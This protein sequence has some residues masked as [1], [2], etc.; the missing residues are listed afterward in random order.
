MPSVFDKSLAEW[1]QFL[2]WLTLA[3]AALAFL[4]FQ[5]AA[6]EAQPDPDRVELTFEGNSAKSET[7][8]RQAAAV[9]LADFEHNGQRRADMD[10]A[11][12]QMASAYR[13][14][15]Y[16]FAKVGYVISQTGGLCTVAFKIEEGPRVLVDKITITGNQAVDRAAIESLLRGDHLAIFGK[17]AHPFVKSDIESAIDS[18][19]D[20]YLNLGFLDVVVPVPQYTFHHDRTRVDI[21]SQIKEGILYRVRRVTFSGDVPADANSALDGLNR[22]MVDQPYTRRLDL[23]VKARAGE[24]LGNLGYPEPAIDVH[25]RLPEGPGPVDLEVDIAKGP[26]V[27]IQDIRIQGVGQ[28]REEFI[29]NRMK[30]K[31][32]DRFNLA[33]ERESSSELFKSGVFSKCDIELEKTEDPSQRVLVVKV[34]EAQ[35]QEV[36][37]EPG[38]GSY[39]QLMMKVGYRHKNVF[40]SALSWNTEVSGSRKAQG[41]SSAL[42]DPWFLDTDL[43]SDL[44]GFADRREEPAFTRRDYGGSFFLTKYLNPSLSLTG[45]YT[46][47]N[48][49][50]SG[51]GT[52]EQEEDFPQNY[53][54]SSVKLQ[55]TYDTRN[56]LFFP[57]TGQRIFSAVEQADSWLGGD[58]NFTRLTLGSRIFF[59]IAAATVLGLRY[60]TGLIIPGRENLTVPPSERFFNGGENTVRSF[61]EFKLGP[62]NSSGKPTGGLGYNVFSVEL[63]QRLIGNFT[64]SIFGD[65]GNVSP[66]RTRAEEGESAYRNHE[67]VTSDTLSDFFRGLRPA[68]GFGLQ[69]QLPIGPARVDVGFNPDRD[70]SRDEDLYVVHLSVGMAF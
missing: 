65:L 6:V 2:R 20:L 38:W 55:I 44:T 53:D 8:L 32:G 62:R 58:V 35:T 42:T 48:T 34:E 60:D 30:L 22:E 63:R 56:D 29:R 33:L 28:T 27:T 52:T 54:F 14:D 68:V 10:D 5:M 12:F 36:Y 31:P 47:R 41:V 37:L 69:Y 17:N 64:G 15:G 43:R 66:K 40:G 57:T 70:K 67:Q 61:K 46:L 16:A 39:E 51:L 24:V 23:V 50:L 21:A 59:R 1:P 25:N 18:I 26:L 45:G 11:A 9:E 4:N 49:D 3:V 13:K 19:R 7:T